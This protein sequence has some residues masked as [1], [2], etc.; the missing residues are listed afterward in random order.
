MFSMSSHLNKD[1]FLRKQL[2]E[3]KF[4]FTPTQQEY[5]TGKN[6][7]QKGTHI[8]CFVKKDSHCYN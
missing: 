2:F 1:K 7:I 4:F 5:F 3:N 8:L 6:L